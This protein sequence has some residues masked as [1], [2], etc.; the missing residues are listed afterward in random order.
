MNDAIRP[1]PDLAR[2][3][4]DAVR[5]EQTADTAQGP[6]GD[7]VASLPPVED[8]TS[9]DV[10]GLLVALGEIDEAR[11]ELLAAAILGD[12]EQVLVAV[13]DLLQATAD[14]TA[15]AR[16][17]YEEDTLG[18]PDPADVHPEEPASD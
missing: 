11:L 15:A 1:K 4:T 7:D 10:G 3:A 5:G 16:T 17:L 6:S 8:A 9:L 18:Q 14:A 13:N 2:I 12:D